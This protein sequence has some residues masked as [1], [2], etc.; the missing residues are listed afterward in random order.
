MFFYVCCHVDLTYTQVL[1]YTSKYLYKI[2][3]ET[4]CNKK[5]M[6]S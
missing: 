4:L 1:F 6:K 5:Y 2:T 3:F